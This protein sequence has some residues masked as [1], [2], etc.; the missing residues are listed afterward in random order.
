M[1]RRTIAGMAVALC[2]AHAAAQPVHSGF[3]VDIAIAKAPAPVSAGGQTRLLYELRIANFYAGEVTLDRIE[4]HAPDGGVL[5]TLSGPA[6]DAQLMAIGAAAGDGPAHV[7]RGGRAVIVFIDLALAPGAPVPTGLSHAFTFKVNL[8]DGRSLERVVSGAP[9]QVGPAAPVIAAPLRGP[10]WVA[11]NGLAEP[12]HRRSFNAVDGHEYL[13]QRLAIDWVR[14]APDGR[15][16]HGD[17]KVN[18]SYP[19]YGA[20]VLAVAEARV[21]AV[22]DGLPENAGNNPA[23]GRTVTLESITGNAIVLD[24]GGGRYA[25]YAHLVP[26]SISVKTGDRVKVGQPIARLGNSG[27]SDA[28]HLHFQLMDANSP[29][30]AEGIPYAI[31]SFAETGVLADLTALDTGT[32]WHPVPGTQR[33]TRHDE[34]PLDNAVV[35]FG[36]AAPR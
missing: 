32:P 21:A 8:P 15:F 23:S 34:F 1:I 36:P 12:D 35:D 20:E 6:L 10:G 33:K 2:V 17:P 19:G 25:L 16:F 11:A 22:I 29:L 28:P 7:L 13:A 3:P 31:A 4:V 5:A 24:L 27:N 30:G 26:G 9:V 14:L 18:A